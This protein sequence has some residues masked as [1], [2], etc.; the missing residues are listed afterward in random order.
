M[1]AAYW[2]LHIDGR[3]SK[4]DVCSSPDYGRRHHNPGGSF[5]KVAKVKK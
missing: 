3:V 4:W 2:A 5:E 1:I